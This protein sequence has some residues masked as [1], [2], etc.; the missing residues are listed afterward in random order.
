MLFNLRPVSID[1]IK[2][3]FSLRKIEKLQSAKILTQNSN[4]KELFTWLVF[5]A[6]LLGII[7]VWWCSVSFSHIYDRPHCEFMAHLVDCNGN[8][9]KIRIDITRNTKC[10]Q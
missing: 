7:K 8:Y 1:D 6:K 3:K 10:Y 2:E 4:F 9:I 5:S